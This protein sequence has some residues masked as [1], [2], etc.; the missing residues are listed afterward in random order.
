M[1]RGGW[2]ATV[3]G[4]GKRGHDWAQQQQTLTCIITF[5]GFQK[6]LSMYRYCSEIKFCFH[7][8]SIIED[9]QSLILILYTYIYLSF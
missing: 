5:L 2:Q 1:D 3:P 8:I 7:F 9:Y 6:F 4:V